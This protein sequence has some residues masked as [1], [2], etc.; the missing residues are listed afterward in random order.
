[1]KILGQITASL[2]IILLLTVT[3][4]GWLAHMYNKPPETAPA[5]T[6]FQVKKGESVSRIASLLEQK[7][8]IRSQTAFKIYARIMKTEGNLQT[9]YYSIPPG[10]TLTGVH[11]ILLK[12]KQYLVTVTI[13]EGYTLKRIGEMLEEKGI[14]SADK[15]VSAASSENLLRELNISG[16]SAQGFIYP[17]TYKLA[18]ET[19]GDML[20]RH[21][22]N[23]F[24]NKLSELNIDTA[25]LSADEIYR[26]VTLASIVEREYRLA[27]EAP[28]IAS[29]FLNRLKINM[30]L[31]SC[32]T[33][34]YVLTDIKQKQ[35]PAVLTYADLEIE[36]DYNTYRHY[37]LPPGPICNP[38]SVALSAAFKP[39]ES[40]Y[41]Y[42]VLEDPSA[43]NHKF[44]ET[45]SQHNAAKQLYIKAR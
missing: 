20:V 32:A 38:G 2:L 19:P 44:T 7:G 14:I 35:H 11:D 17:D 8:F 9:G 40:P 6:F 23:T 41:L 39:A 25:G 30:P 24:R 5:D 21:M 28:L 29:V 1:M 33:V 15:F 42:F 31:Q 43:G 12:G 10:A 3:G 36:S 26:K 22:V 18:L 37:G 13:P 16:V 27:G 4:F 45:L 34:V